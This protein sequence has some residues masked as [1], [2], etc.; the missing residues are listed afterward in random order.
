MTDDAFLREVIACPHDAACRLVYADWLD[1][2]G[3]PRG[4]YLRA[5]A[6][7]A[8]ER[9][10]TGARELRALAAGLDPVWVAR[11]SRPPAGVCCDRVRFSEQG[12]PLT[13]ADLARVEADLAVRFPAEFRAFYLN[14]NGGQPVPSEVPDPRPNWSDLPLEISRFLTA[15][16]LAEELQFL[17]Y[18]AEYTW[19]LGPGGNPL[20][21]DLV[22]FADTQHD[23][24]HFFIGVGEANFGRVFHFTDYCHHLDDPGHLLDMATSFGEILSR[25]GQH[26]QP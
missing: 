4:A 12:L 17:H 10:D 1:E 6:E 13:P 5:E 11:V 23:L 24:G 3:D 16:Q 19:A 2:R 26:T 22:L 21:R 9:A 18:L 20:L 14:C 8:K 15:D 7:W 25:I